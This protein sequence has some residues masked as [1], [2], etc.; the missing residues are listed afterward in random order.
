MKT[1]R[2][3]SIE[4][5]GFIY[6]MW[7]EMREAGETD[8]WKDT[9]TLSIKVNAKVKELLNTIC[10]HYNNDNTYYEI[11]WDIDEYHNYANKNPYN[12]HFNIFSKIDDVDEFC[13]FEVDDDEVI[14]ENNE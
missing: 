10:K 13:D 7:E 12:I 4:I 2:E 6:S 11:E 1:A 9:L 5:T 3:L 14:E 8:T